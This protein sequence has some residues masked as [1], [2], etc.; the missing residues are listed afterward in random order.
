MSEASSLQE[1]NLDAK[2][3]KSGVINQWQVMMLEK[4]SYSKEDERQTWSV[5]EAM[6]RHISSPFVPFQLQNHYYLA[7]LRLIYGRAAE[8]PIILHSAVVR[9]TFFLVRVYIALQ[10]FT[11]VELIFRRTKTAFSL[12]QSNRRR[13]AWSDEIIGVLCAQSDE[14]FH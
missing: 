13:G 10:F 1:I 7:D 3:D 11:H 6:I 4:G 14:T 9:N 2:A 5:H 12:S 8:M